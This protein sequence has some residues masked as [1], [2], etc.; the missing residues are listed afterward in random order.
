LKKL[1]KNWAVS[2]QAAQKFDKERIN[3]R[4]LNEQEVWKQY[5]FEMSTRFVA[6]GNL[7]NK[8]DTNRV[9]ENIKERI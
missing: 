5:Q 4:K 3:L 7:S 9:W 1:G 2:K 6:L 8:E